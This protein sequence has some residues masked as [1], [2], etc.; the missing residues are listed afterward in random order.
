MSS[1]SDLKNAVLV[2][3]QLPTL[4][5]NEMQSSLLEL[6]R[7]VTTLGYN[8]IGQLTQKRTT[9][10]SMA[11]LGDGKLAELATWTGGTGKIANSFVRKKHKA[12]L[13]FKPDEDDPDTQPLEGDLGYDILQ[14]DE[15]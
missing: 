5:D 7:L 13:R 15:I 9:D 3:I 14:D 4:S 12:A 2:G 8:V 6:T 1:N 10:K 11:V